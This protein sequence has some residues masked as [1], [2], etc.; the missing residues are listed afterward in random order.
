[1]KKQIA[2]FLFITIITV[3][4]ACVN[5][6]EFLERPTYVPSSI[7]VETNASR[8]LFQVYVD[9]KLFQDSVSINKP[10][11][12][13]RIEAGEHKIQIKERTK[14]NFFIDSSAVLTRED[15]FNL[16]LLETN[17]S[18]DPVKFS[19][20]P[21]S[22]S[23]PKARF[24]KV[25][26]LNGQFKTEINIKLLDYDLRKTITEFKNLPYQQSSAFFEISD[27]VLNGGYYIEVIDSKTNQVLLRRNYSY[28]FL[29]DPKKP[30][31]NLFIL[32]FINSRTIALPFYAFEEIYSIKK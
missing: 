21:D 6:D 10:L 18:L 29:F 16:F 27:V 8:K 24:K 5:T 7:S 23:A 22:V 30:N 25:A 19:G 20:I 12:S 1:M 13:Q 26:F 2:Y 28:Y 11:N 32:N 17:P 3:V 14:A 9:G 31:N 15:G 4:T